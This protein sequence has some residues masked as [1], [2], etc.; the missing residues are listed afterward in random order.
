MNDRIEAPSVSHDRRSKAETAR[1]PA[2]RQAK[3]AAAVTGHTT[4]SALTG[5]P[6]RIGRRTQSPAAQNGTE[7]T[8]T[9]A[10]K[11]TAPSEGSVR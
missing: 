6:G 5:S 9:Q 11:G 2:R 4:A 8:K 10:K 1:A 3:I 7:S